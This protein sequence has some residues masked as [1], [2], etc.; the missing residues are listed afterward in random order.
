MREVL[1]AGEMVKRA[2][3]ELV[4]SV[5]LITKDAGL[6]PE[7]AEEFHVIHRQLRNVTDDV[8]DIVGNPHWGLV[9]LMARV[10][11]EKQTKREETEQCTK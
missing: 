7:L 11:A 4:E 6:S 8:R 2:V 5:E 9:Q 1:A 3:G 10:E